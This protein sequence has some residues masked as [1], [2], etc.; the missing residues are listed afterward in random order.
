MYNHT[1]PDALL[2]ISI[3][4]IKHFGERDERYIYL[5]YCYS[6]DTIKTYSFRMVSLYIIDLRV[7][8]VCKVAIV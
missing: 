6:N 3:V 1:F 4:A 2:I 8:T 5:I 7:Y